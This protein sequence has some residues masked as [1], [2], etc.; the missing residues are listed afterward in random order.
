[1]AAI[2]FPPPTWE[3]AFAEA[4]ALYVTEPETL[5]RLRPA[6]HAFFVKRFPR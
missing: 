1:M 3:E 2:R 5:R 6:V 4:Y